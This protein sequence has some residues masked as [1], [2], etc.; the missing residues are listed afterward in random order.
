MAIVGEA[1]IIVRAL[2]N[3]V[4]GDIKRGFSGISTSVAR[5]AGESMG[6]AFTR[7]F[8]QS[9]N[10]NVFSR[11][12]NGLRAMSPQAEATRK[13]FAAM[14]KVGMTLQ[15]ALGVLIGGISAVIGGLVGLIGSAGGAAA[16]LAIVGNAGFAMA[17]GMIAAKLALGGV[18]KALSALN[19]Q[20]GGAADNTRQIEEA[21]RRLALVIESNRENLID[22]NN[23]VREAQLDLNEA[24]KQGREE[25][26]QLG[27]EAED[28]ALAEQQAALDLQKAREVL[29]RVQDLPPN[30]RVRKEAE[31]AYQEAEL[32]LRKAKDRSADLNK[33]Q[34]RLARTGVSGTAVVISATQ[35][36][37]EAEARKAKV[38]RDGIRDQINAEEALAD[39]KKGNA[40][41]G[42]D[43]FAGLNQFQIDFVKFLASLKPKLDELKLAVSE[44]FLPPLQTAITTLVDGLF[45]TIKTGLTQVAAAL[46]LAAV[47]LA[48]VMVEARNVGNLGSLFESSAQLIVSFGQVIGNV[49]SSMLSILVAA[50]PQAQRFADFLVSTTKDFSDF[51]GR[52]QADGTMATF[53]QKA[54]D[55]AAK[56][57]KIFGNIFAGIGG[58][59]NA[60]LGPGTGGDYLLNWLIDA[61]EKFRNLGKAGEDGIS[62][63]AEYFNKVAVNAQKVLSSIGALLSELIALGANESIG[64]TFDILSKGAKPL[65]DIIEAGANAGPAFATLIVTLTEIGA[66][67]SDTTQIQYFFNTFQF[68][69]QKVRDFLANELVQ[70]ILDTISPFL[71]IA[72]ALGTMAA[73]AGKAFSIIIGYV[74]LFASKIGAVFGFIAA[75]PVVAIIIAIAAAMVY[76]YNTNE[77]FAASVNAVFGQLM[78]AFGGLAETLGPV[79][80]NLISSLIPVFGVLGD[81]ITQILTALVP[82][83]GLIITSLVPV[84]ASIVTVISEVLIAI[85]PMVSALISALAPALVLVIDA[86]MSL[87]TAIAPLIPQLIDALLPAFMSIIDALMPL[88]VMLAEQV[89]PLFAELLASMAPLIATIIAAVIPVLIQ[90]VQAFA[91]LI[92]TILGELI[93]IL[94][95]LMQSF[96]PVVQ[97]IAET[98]IPVIVRL[99]QSM[100]PLIM[101]IIEMLVPVILTLIDTFLPLVGTIIEALVPAI[102]AI[103]TA[104]VPLINLILP[105]LIALIELLMPIVK[106]LADL[107]IGPLSIAIMMISGIIQLLTGNFEG[108]GRT[109]ER[110]WTGIKN[111]GRNIVNDIIGIFEGMINFVI[112]GINRMIS[113]INSIKVTVPDWI[114]DL[115][116]MRSNTFGFNIPSLGKVS[117]PR[118]AEGGVVAPSMG[119]TIAQIAEAGRPE[120]VEPLDA[121]GMSKRDKYIVELIKAQESNAGTINITV[122]PAP[123]M[124]E[125]ELAAAV[126]RE[127]S[128]QMRRGAVA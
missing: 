31:L 91:P 117:I 30:S 72:A 116:K 37:A 25:I 17:A 5:K 73:L 85:M 49:Y 8:N 82:L 41:G 11:L 90:L 28:A 2:T 113:F 61:T 99:I 3:K 94:M 118:L 125:R 15:T 1:H 47:N 101:T 57:G 77:Q 98:V 4:D 44:A 105:P 60:N 40:G 123:G 16:S 36:L 59:I 23:A 65:G 13:A 110:I 6:N 50:A 112:D 95:I 33:E 75:N 26:Q 108:F 29:A 70:R 119:G 52:A 76:L 124:D 89:I 21:E 38:V 100:M 58:V 84:F 121:N 122:N 35:R 80:Q 107:F 9:A 20:S 74:G 114:R 111:F 88:V 56:F 103:I 7:G 69:A 109:F 10:S 79:M 78:Q 45:P 115:L 106:L 127:I 120:R 54:G 46:G 39:A 126:S 68:F 71:G 66:L 96:M 43:P 48:N 34:D 12:A 102:L 42:S 92:A 24:L 67:L 64:K 55:A 18:G 62:P 81:A 87:I 86:V 51:T 27:F 53:F 83:I 19:R 32:N 104:F 93:P 128:F 22:A 14:V 63:M 97:M